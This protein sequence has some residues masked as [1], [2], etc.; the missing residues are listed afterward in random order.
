MYRE[1]RPYVTIPNS[2]GLNMDE[3]QLEVLAPPP[4]AG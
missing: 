2:E 1:Y 4:L 3:N